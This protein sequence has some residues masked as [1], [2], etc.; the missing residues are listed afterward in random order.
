MKEI[1][2][3]II[4]FI[5]INLLTALAC[6]LTYDTLLFDTF[7]IVLGYPQ[8]I[9]LALISNLLFTAIPQPLKNDTKREKI[10]R[11]IFKNGF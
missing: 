5:V 2:K 4:V 6:K 9:A 11:D 10:S 8:W 7:K 3:K 1:I